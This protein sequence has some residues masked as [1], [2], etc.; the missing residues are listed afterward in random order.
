[1]LC[2]FD[3]CLLR[4]L[5]LLLNDSEEEQDELRQET[6]VNEQCEQFAKY[7]REMADYVCACCGVCSR[8]KCF[9]DLIMFHSA[10]VNR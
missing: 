3:S 8:K 2:G 6:H 10:F 1:M 4:N 5:Y 9:R 7:A